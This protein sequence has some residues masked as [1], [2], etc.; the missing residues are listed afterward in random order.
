MLPTSPLSTSGHMIICEEEVGVTMS[1][2]KRWDRAGRSPPAPCSAAFPAKKPPS[3]GVA[4]S[5][6]E[7]VGGKSLMWGSIHQD[8]RIQLAAGW[9]SELLQGTPAVV[10]TNTA[11]APGT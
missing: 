4:C 7:S 11:S 5:E 8:R 9:G 6:N 2:Q 1:S 3:D 10:E